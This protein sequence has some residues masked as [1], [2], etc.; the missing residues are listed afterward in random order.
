MGGG[1]AAKCR[2]YPAFWDH[3]AAGTAEQGSD[4]GTNL[5][6]ATARSGSAD[7]G[8]NQAGRASQASGGSSLA[9]E[10]QRDESMHRTGGWSSKNVT[11]TLP[12]YGA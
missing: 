9:A 10:K 12:F 1:V 3:A 8:S 4:D 6:R 11:D 7:N 5:S 2:A